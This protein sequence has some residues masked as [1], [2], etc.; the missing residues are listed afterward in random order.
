MIVVRDYDP[1]AVM[2]SAM[3]LELSCREITLGDTLPDLNTEDIVCFMTPLGNGGKSYHTELITRNPGVKQWVVI[4]FSSDQ[5]AAAMYREK[6][7]NTGR[8]IRFLEYSNEHTAD[9]IQA[10]RSI[11]TTAEKTCLIY[12][13]RSGPALEEFA[14]YLRLLC[15]EW[16]FSVAWEDPMALQGS[17]EQL[18]IVGTDAED[19]QI[20]LP[21][22]LIQIPLFAL[23]R[24]EHAIQLTLHP[25]VI[26]TDLAR[27]LECTFRWNQA[28]IKARFFCV[29]VLYESWYHLYKNQ[30]DSVP[31]LLVDARLVIWDKYGLPVPTRQCSTESVLAFLRGFTGCAELAA[32]IR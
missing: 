1:Q 14:D 17:W 18:I 12:S 30:P 20:E 4:L 9:L 10:L 25:G 6:L 23:L 32:H 27:K 26:L 5:D 3:Y 22:S 11:G 8:N 24:A 2:P 15:P 28:Q 13:R 19:F 7:K 29:S 31:A 16:T 21:S